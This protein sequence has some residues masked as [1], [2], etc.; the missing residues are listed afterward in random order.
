MFSN[1]G[2]EAHFQNQNF[3]LR[4]LFKVFQKIF[5]LISMF[6]VCLTKFKNYF[7][8]GRVSKKSYIFNFSKFCFRDHVLNISKYFPYHENT[9]IS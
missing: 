3:V 1:E 2:N 9:R 5:F 8:N 7:R 6:N 4:N